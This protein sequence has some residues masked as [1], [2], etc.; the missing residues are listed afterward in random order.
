MSRDTGRF[1]VLHLSDVHATES[2]LLYG[3]VDGAGR[4]ERVGDYAL[5]AGITPEVVLITGD[6]IERGNPGAYPAVA[7]ACRRLEERLG[8]PVLT[9]LGNHD[10][11]IAARTL[12]HHT[13]GHVAAHTIDGVRVIRLDSHRGELDPAQLEWL[14]AELAR[15]A[16][17]GTVIALHHAPLASPLP[18]LRR[19][20]LANA[21]ALLAVL[22]GSDVLA[23]LAGHYHHS[24]AASVQG[25]PVFVGPSL[26]YHQ[27]MDAGPD[28]V[29][30]HDAPMFS[31]VQITGDGV[32]ASAIALHSPDPLFTQ[33]ITRPA[34]KATHVS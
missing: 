28:A 16:E 5:A 34:Q 33:P 30:G 9:V 1:T 27:V 6:L 25:I 12:P 10:D 17:R 24:L 19:Q 2:G 23:I 32:S 15:P 11:P 8:A 3:A 22:R 4:I 20:G 31:L 7:A 29:A 14:A 26:A 13:A 21:D 18:T